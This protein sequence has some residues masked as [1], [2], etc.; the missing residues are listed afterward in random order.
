[1]RVGV[2]QLEERGKWRKRKDREARIRNIKFYRDSEQSELQ[3]AEVKITKKKGI[4]AKP[5]LS[6]C[7]G[8]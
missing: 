1:M 3:R 2:G 7:S 6:F 4:I 8:F 5:A